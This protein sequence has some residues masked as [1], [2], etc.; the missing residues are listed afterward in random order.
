[1]S[2]HGAVAAAG[3]DPT[4]APRSACERADAMPGAPAARSAGGNLLPAAA[5]ATAVQ[6]SCPAISVLPAGL[7]RHRPLV[8]VAEDDDDEREML[9]LM[10][11]LRGFDVVLSINGRDALDAILVQGP[12]A[13]VSDMNMPHL[14]GLGLCRAVRALPA[15]EFLPVILYSG[16]GA[17]DPRLLEAIALGG[18]VVLSKSLAASKID[19]VLQQVLRP[20]DLQSSQPRSTNGLG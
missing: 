7:R 14:D 1:V 9:G 8:V 13:V 10:L 17:D 6:G 16:V 3:E 4:G 20:T 12:D 19:V 15:A 2:C 18:V 11:G 5:S